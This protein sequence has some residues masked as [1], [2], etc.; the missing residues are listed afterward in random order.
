MAREYQ[1]K[2]NVDSTKAEAALSKFE[3]KAQRTFD[4]LNKTSFQP[5][6]FIN[7]IHISINEIMKLAAKE[8][9]AAAKIAKAEAEVA[10]AKEKTKQENAK[11]RQESQKTAQAE[12]K[13]QADVKKARAEA[14]KEAEKTAQVEVSANAAVAKAR[15]EARKEATKLREEEQ[16]TAR[17]AEKTAREEEKTAQ[18][19]KKANADVAKEKQKTLQQELKLQQQEEKTAQ[20]EKR[21]T[22]E[23]IKGMNQA[24]V[25]QQKVNAEYIKGQQANQREAEKTRQ[26]ELKLE[27]QQEKT[28]QKFI[29]SEQKKSSTARQGSNEIISS[30]QAVANNFTKV[31]GQMTNAW[32]QLKMVIGF[33]GVAGALRSAFNEM[34]AMSDEL[35]TYQKVTGASSEQVAKVRQSAY[36]SAYRYGQ[37]PSDFLA[38]VAV[39]A[40]AGYGEQ[41]EAMAD[42]AT[43]TQLVGDMTSEAASQFLIAVDAG[44][45]L[46]GNV[47]ALTNVLDKANIIDNNYATSLS[48]VADAMTLIAPLSA[49]MNV[50]IEETMAAIG[51]MSA[52][53]QRQGTEVARAYR[54]IA[55]NIAKDTETEVEEGVKLTEEEIK[56]LNDIL[57]VYAATELKAADAAGKLLSPMKA[58]EAISRAWKSGALNEQELFK[59]LNGI[60]G[61][62]YTN[63][64][65]ALVKNFDMYEDML[66]KFVTEMGSADAEV[67]AMTKGWTAKFNQLKVAWTEM[68]NNAV[69][70]D[71]I[72]QL[73]DISK[74]FIQWTGNLQTFTGVVGGTTVTLKALKAILTGTKTAFTGFGLAIGAVTLALSAL[75]AASES[76]KRAAQQEAQAAL[77]AT[78]Q[79]YEKARSI[80]ELSRAYRQLSKDGTI[81]DT[82]LD[83]ART[84]QQDINTLVGELPEKYDL[85]AGSIDKNVEALQRMNSEQRQAAYIRAQEA[86]N[87]SGRALV[88]NGKDFMGVFTGLDTE[89]GTL[90]KE[91]YLESAFAN[92]EYFRYG[93]YGASLNPVVQYTGEKTAEQIVAA[94]DELCQ[95]IDKATAADINSEGYHALI[96]TRNQWT[97]LITN[98]KDA[99][100][101]L[102]LIKAGDFSKGTGGTAGGAGSGSTGTSGTDKETQSWDRLAKA[103]D[104]ATKAKEDFDKANETSKADQIKDYASVYATL[105]EELK[106]GRVN[107]TATHAALQMLLGDEAYAATGGKVTALQEAWTGKRAGQMLSAAES[108]EILTGTYQNQN[109]Q[110]VEGAGIAVLAEKVGME[111]RDELGNYM[112]D[113][114]DTAKLEQLSALTGVTVD[115]LRSALNA[116][117]QYDITGTSTGAGHPQEQDEVKTAEESLGDSLNSNKKSVD[118]LTDSVNSLNSTLGGGAGG[119][120][121][122]GTPSG[123]GT[124]QAINGFHAMLKAEELYLAGQEEKTFAEQA[125]ASTYVPTFSG[126]GMAERLEQAYGV[127]THEK[128]TPT[129]VQETV[130]GTPDIDENA[131]SALPDNDLN[132]Q[133]KG[134]DTSRFGALGGKSGSVEPEAGPKPGIPTPAPN[135]DTGAL[136]VLPE[137][138]LNSQINGGISYSEEHASQHRL[139]NGPLPGVGE[140]SDAEARAE[141]TE[142]SVKETAEGIGKI[143]DQL[144]DAS[145]EDLA[146][147][148]AMLNGAQ[149]GDFSGYEGPY[150]IERAYKDYK[151]QYGE[152][153][154][155]FIYDRIDEARGGGLTED[156]K[157]ISAAIEPIIDKYQLDDIL[158]SLE[159]DLNDELKP[160]VIDTVLNKYSLEQVIG[161]LDLLT[162]ENR[163]AVIQAAIAKYGK[164]AVIAELKKIATNNGG[165][166][167]AEIIAELEPSSK[168]E[169]KRQLREL[170]QASTKK[171]YTQVITSGGPYGVNATAHEAVGSSSYHGGS[172]LVNDGTGAELVL[173]SHG[174][175]V[176]GGGNPTVTNIERGAMIYTAEQTRSL[177][178]S[179]PHHATGNESNAAAQLA[180]ELN[181]FFDYIRTGDTKYTLTGSASSKAGTGS[182]T[183]A[184]AD[185]QWKSLQELIEYIIKRLGK[186]LE[187]QEKVIDEQIKALQAQKSQRD[188]QSKIE[189]LQKAVAEAQSNLA[190]AQSQRS[191]RYID[192]NGQWHWMADKKKVQ[193]AQEALDN[194]NKSFVDY[195]YEAS[196]DAQVKALEDEKTRLSDEYTGYKDLWSD[197]LDAVATP[198]GDLVALIQYLTANGTGAQRNGA[199]AVKEQLITAM[200]GGSYKANYNEALGEIGKAAANNPSVPGISDAALAALI[201]SSGT[202]VSSGA[203]LGALQSIAGNNA[204][205]GNIGGSTTNTDNSVQYFINGVQIGS[206][207]ANMPL[208]EI[209]QRLSVYANASL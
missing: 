89:P 200:L 121:G 33:A 145:N 44:Y 198:T 64:I 100:E 17:E 150:D 168:E 202:S 102:G 193:Q 110:T 112:L 141:S 177:I 155:D 6:A 72:R 191:V 8:Q 50:S 58:I 10:K 53:T 173:D 195:L 57:Q 107:S 14:R 63:S 62:R 152:G 167:A 90:K 97:E 23:R 175:H 174:A 104:N 16:K 170:T 171:I 98:Y 180:A 18:V 126:M 76:R 118:A 138:D 77:D 129:F 125:S 183:K 187:A 87:T 67:D 185:D 78:K 5:T 205:V 157:A 117:D 99:L 34:K 146:Y 60:G 128:P 81:D 203:M 103:I 3:Q 206:N 80:D 22:Q 149:T 82:E 189:E 21:I 114:T 161:S 83:Q 164:D 106:N 92:S 31:T 162:E 130:V 196:I 165:G 132:R 116:Y 2:I 127:G 131:L 42:L 13:A 140:S 113:F 66:S 54:M 201:A 123:G 71:F 207:M 182:D 20:A 26:Q 43:K 144:E 69:S 119:E 9:E 27:Q 133:L 153:V 136:V 85:V 96:E 166:W 70:E 56:S 204:V 184:K 15:A 36:E 105:A 52:V 55:L 158:S 151:H 47:E 30:H 190:E 59:V 169:A 11:A 154:M 93:R 160:I 65:M 41:S 74:G 40:R 192:D 94:Y 194:A 148:R 109:G 1:V 84:I 61:A 39:M 147:W 68:V 163:T 19:K 25:T 91:P 101:F 156:Q 120:A 143:V 208:S 134:V 75:N 135:V 35:I 45:Q 29:Q 86:V 159:Y 24:Y 124:S 188:E 51:T 181:A 79:E 176:Y 142:T 172:A 139:G 115:A 186:A 73:L 88:E 137:N 38:S 12:V 178:A 197:I 199:T 48:K 7:G 46:K 209:L 49:S 4:K 37:T 95:I 122:G 179:V 108:Y 111:V 32:N 28:A